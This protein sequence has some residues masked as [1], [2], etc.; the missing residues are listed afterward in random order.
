M[1]TGAKKQPRMR[2]KTVR[3]GDVR[4]DTAGNVTMIKFVTYTDNESAPAIFVNGVGAIYEVG[5]N[6]VQVVFV[7]K[8]LNA[9]GEPEVT[10]VASFI[11]DKKDWFDSG[12]VFRYAMELFRLPP[13]GVGDGRRRRIEQPGMN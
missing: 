12:N 11:W 7:R 4:R 10:A 3:Y 5:E 1:V 6:S 2:R 9:E 13:Q 8:L